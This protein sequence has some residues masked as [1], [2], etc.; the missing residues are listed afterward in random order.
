MHTH[1]P[2]YFRVFAANAGGA[3]LQFLSELL[4]HGPSWE[5]VPSLL[6]GLASV[7]GATKIW[8]DS[9]QQRR[10]AEEEHRAKLGCLRRC[11]PGIERFN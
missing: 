11:P 7:I 3:T 6:M 9:A 8:L 2:M 4:R 1:N 5:L 10:H